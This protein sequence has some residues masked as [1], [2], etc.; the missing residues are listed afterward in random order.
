LSLAPTLGLSTKTV[1]IKR[2]LQK[3]IPA[4]EQ[5]KAKRKGTLVKA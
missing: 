3:A 5:I 4:K 2:R 1:A